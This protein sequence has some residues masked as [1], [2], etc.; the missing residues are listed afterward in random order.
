MKYIAALTGLL[1]ISIAPAAV[2]GPGND[3]AARSEKVAVTE[4]DDFLKACL[5]EAS[6][7][8]KIKEAKHKHKKA[9]C[10][11]NAKNMKLQGKDKGEYQED[12]LNKNQAAEVKSTIAVADANATPAANEKGSSSKPAEHKHAAKKQKEHK[13]TSKKNSKK[14]VKLSPAA[15]GVAETK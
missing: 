13:K 14:A 1:L 11:Q 8:A 5:A 6:D 9:R 10:E 2:A 15:S 7:P 3:C 4:K 12:C